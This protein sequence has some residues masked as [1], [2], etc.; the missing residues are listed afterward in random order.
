MGSIQVCGQSETCSHVALV[1]SCQE[2][3]TPDDSNEETLI[4]IYLQNC[5]NEEENKGD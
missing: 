4:K 5:E 1:I 2:N 3:F